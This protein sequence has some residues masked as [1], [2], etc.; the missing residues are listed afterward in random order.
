MKSE[1]SAYLRNEVIEWSATYAV[2]TFETSRP[3]LTMS[4]HREIVLQKSLCRG[5]QKFR[6]LQAR[7]S[8][9]DLRD[10]IASR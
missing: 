5:G 7:F 4:V 6:G 8:C 10:L 9:K 2:G 3:A 1:P